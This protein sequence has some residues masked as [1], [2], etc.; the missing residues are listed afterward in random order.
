[1]ASPSRPMLR[2]QQRTRLRA[3][4]PDASKS[5][6]HLLSGAAE[7]SDRGSPGLHDTTAQLSAEQHAGGS[8]TRREARSDS[9]WA[10]F[11]S[12][13]G[14][15]LTY[16]EASLHPENLKLLATAARSTF[17]LTPWMDFANVP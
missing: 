2:A 1:V 13:A 8:G 9:G 3:A 6:G 16:L 17:L 4:R 14:D 11:R 10:P 7:G 5:P 15:M 12:T